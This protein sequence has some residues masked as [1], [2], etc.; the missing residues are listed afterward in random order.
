[1][2]SPLKYRPLGRTGVQLS[3]LGLGTW[4]F[5]AE[6]DE[7]ES[8][9]MF[10]ASVDRGINF[11]DTADVYGNGVSEEILGRQIQGIRDELV[12][13]TKVYGATGDGVNSGG[14]SRRHLSRAIEASLKRLGTDRVDIYFMHQFDERTPIEETLRGMEDL[15]RRGLILYPGVSNWAA[16]QIATALGVSALRN[17]TRIEVIQPMYSLVKRQAEVELLPLADTEDLCVTPYSPLGSGILTGKYRGGVIPAD[18]R[19][20]SN[21][22]HA[23]RY[24]DPQ[25]HAVAGRFDAFARNM[26]VHPATLA[27]SWVASHPSVTA[28]ILGARNLEQLIPSLNSV[29]FQMTSAMRDEITALSPRLPSPTD[30]TEKP[31]ESTRV[32][33]DSAQHTAST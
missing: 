8:S 22:L 5:G 33:H 29:T 15:V 20:G 27:V 18:S 4:S 26:G 7:A 28:P 3:S 17:L 30:Q 32:K 10:R 25:Y 12:I 13:A 2:G 23:D 1:M 24:A 16:W 9:K 14:L 19:L 11:F 31:Q 21:P 6:A